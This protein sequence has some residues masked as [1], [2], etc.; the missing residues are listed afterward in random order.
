[1]QKKSFFHLLFLYLYLCRMENDEFRTVVRQSEGSYSELRSKF[2]AFAYPVN[3]VDAAMEIVT[4]MKRKYYDARHVAYAYMIGVPD[5][6]PSS[7]ARNR[8]SET[9]IMYA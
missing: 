9:P 4:H 2:L 6:S 8:A 1:M 5:G 3:S 7:F